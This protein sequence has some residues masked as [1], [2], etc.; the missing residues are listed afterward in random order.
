MEN[1]SLYEN[2]IGNISQVTVSTYQLTLD[3]VFTILFDENGNIVGPSCILPENLIQYIH[4][5][6]IQSNQ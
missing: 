2:H 6:N 1:N 4:Q 3:N 5:Y